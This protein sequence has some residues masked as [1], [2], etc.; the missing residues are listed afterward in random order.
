MSRLHTVNKSPHAAP[1][2]ADC[3]R[4]ASPGDSVLLI[5]DGVYAAI[6][7]SETAAL[8][9][10]HA[11]RLYALQADVEARGLSHCLAEDV[12]LVDDAGFVRLCCAARDLCSWY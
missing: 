7:S 3:L 1:A 12:E 6:S 10:Q 2:L 5:E 4:A 11:L 9:R 8:C